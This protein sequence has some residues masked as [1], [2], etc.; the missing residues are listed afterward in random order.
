MNKPLKDCTI[1]ELEQQKE[2]QELIMKEHKIKNDK[3]MCLL[4]I[5]RMTEINRCIDLMKKKNPPK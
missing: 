1:K 4:D 2:Q 5:Q 3:Y